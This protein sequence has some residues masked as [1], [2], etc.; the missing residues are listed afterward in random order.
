[1]KVITLILITLSSFTILNAQ[2]KESKSLFS[3]GYQNTITADNGHYLQYGYQFGTDKKW[4]QEILLFA[5]FGGSNEIDSVVVGGNTIITGGQLEVNAEVGVGY[6]FKNKIVQHKKWGLALGYGGTLGYTNGRFIPRTSQNF[7]SVQQTIALEIAFLGEIAYDLSKKL[8]LGIGII[9]TP[10]RFEYERE[11]TENPILPPRQRVATGL[12][13]D[14]S[15]NTDAF[16]R[17]GYIF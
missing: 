14:L 15:N 1:M 12:G 2:K 16:I 13:F 8:Q 5:R 7:P 9:P 6:F 10:A 11:E 3:I 17:L 4:F